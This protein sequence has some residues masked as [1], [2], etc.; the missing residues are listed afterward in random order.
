MNAVSGN[1]THEYSTKLKHIILNLPISY[2]YKSRGHFG[3][4][5]YDDSCT[6][7]PIFEHKMKIIYACVQTLPTYTIS[8]HNL[9]ILLYKI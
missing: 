2:S 9:V 6:C 3:P 5:L 8:H 4:Q 1:N 7:N